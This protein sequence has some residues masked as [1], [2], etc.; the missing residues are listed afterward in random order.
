MK[1]ELLPNEQYFSTTLPYFD[2]LL[3]R[4]CVGIKEKICS[5]HS[6]K[7]AELIVQ[8]TYNQFSHSCVSEIVTDFLT[9]YFKNLLQECWENAE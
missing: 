1:E 8:N 5:A 4:Y 2:E 9:H 6:R 7:E 3:N